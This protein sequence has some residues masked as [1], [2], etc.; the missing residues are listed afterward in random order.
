MTSG[1]VVVDRRRL[2]MVLTIGMA[3]FFLLILTIPGSPGRLRAGSWIGLAIAL[4]NL[5][6]IQRLVANHERWPWLA[7]LAAASMAAGMG[8]AAAD[9][10]PGEESQLFL[11]WFPWIASYCGVLRLG[12]SLAMAA[13]VALTLLLA[14]SVNSALAGSPALLIT[15]AVSSAGGCLVMYVLFQW[16]GEQAYSDPLTSLVARSGLTRAADPAIARAVKKDGAAVLLLLDI[17]RFREVNDALGHEA[18]DELL[19]QLARALPAVTPRPSFVGRL[20]SDEFALVIAVPAAE[21]RRDDELGDGDAGRGALD[22][23]GAGPGGPRRGGSTPGSASRESG[24]R[25]LGESVLRQIEGPFTV[26]GVE[27]EVEASAGLAAAPR[28]G[29]T[30]GS[31]LPCADAA[32]SRAK[33]EGER[34]GLW[35]AGIAG[36]RSWE[37]A[38]YAELRAAIARDELIVFYQ[39]L[40]AAATGRIVGVEA[41]VR[42]SHPTRG[43]LPPGAFLPM[44]ERSALIV[45]VTRWVLD[46]ALRQ[47]AAWAARGLHVPVSVNLSAR[48]LVLDDLP[49]LVTGSLARHQLPPDVLTL[50]IT[51]SALVTQPGRAA[52]MLRELRSKGVKLALDDFGTGYSSMEILKALP[53]DEVKIDRGFV[54]DARGSLPDAAIVRSV[55]DLGHRLG[56]RVVGEGVEDERTLRMMTELGCDILQ[57]D[58]ISRPRPPAHLEDLLVARTAPTDRPG[59]AGATLPAGDAVPAGV[60]GVPTGGDGSAGDAV[61]AARSAPIVTQ[62]GTFTVSQTRRFG[63]LAPPVADEAARVA[64]TRRYEIAF[65]PRTYPLDDMAALAAAMTGCNVGSVLLVGADRETYLGRHGHDMNDVPA[66]VGVASHAVAAGEL[67]EVPDSMLDTRFAHGTRAFPGRP[68]RFIA[69][70]PVRTSDGHAIGAVTISDRIPRRLTPGQR[71]ALESLARHAA[72]MMD[73]RREAVL[74]AVVTDTARALDQL[75]YPDDLPAAASL[76]SDAARHMLGG[77]VVTVLMSD[78]PG[79]TVYSSVGASRAP[80]A[81]SII[82][83]GQRFSSNDETVIGEVLR[84]QSPLFVPDAPTFPGFNLDIVRTSGVASAFLVPIPGEGGALGVMCARWP[85]PVAAIDPSLYRAMALLAGQAGHG[86]GRLRAAPTG[87]RRTDGAAGPTSRAEFLSTLQGLSPGTAV[88]LFDVRA[89][90]AAGLDVAGLRPGAGDRR[91][92]ARDRL[93]GRFAEHLRAVC[94]ESTQLARWSVSR[95]AVAIPTGGRERAEAMVDELRRSWARESA[96]PIAVGISVTR[97]HEPSS[98]ALIDAENRLLEK[99]ALVTRAERVAAARVT[100]TSAGV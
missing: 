17:N 46:E 7:A 86:L 29:E 91:A 15:A 97:S 75:W 9:A 5:A 3:G 30:I 64:A 22:R 26:H 6:L 32:L 33:R 52:A 81:T 95:F 85:D 59:P 2:L 45:D 67:V 63:V 41:L 92:A 10:V 44:A 43:L 89:G 18:G 66:R 48:M 42:W 61:D 37:I 40:Q 13:W 38:L 47:C 88:C 31:L 100:A 19:R 1:P 72:V 83:P 34:V 58:A 68:I 20:G 14:A 27:V 11:L 51:E 54:A 24:L 71:E 70:V 56:L 80:G 65:Q 79:S 16:R 87:E 82:K 73:V 55:L 49:S 39:P 12:W 74:L 4:V 69:A 62:D 84:T 60:G 35:D 77:D 96:A 50:E 36:V 21:D 53:F 28:D 8:T 99:L 57:G 23:G 25:E 78:A 93:T 76:V 94:D 98:A 90:D